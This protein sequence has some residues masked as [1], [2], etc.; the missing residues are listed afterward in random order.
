M[1]AGAVYYRARI[2][3]DE[4]KLHDLPPGTRLTPGMPVVGDIKVGKRT[5]FQYLMSRVIPATT[6]GMR[7]P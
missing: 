6:E 3:I 1:E 7:E 2:S 5:F 4:M